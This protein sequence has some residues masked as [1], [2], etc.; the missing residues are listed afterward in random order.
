VTEQQRPDPNDPEKTER[1][2]PDK[3]ERVEPDKTERADSGKQ[4]DWSRWEGN[5]TERAARDAQR[6]AHEHAR[7]AERLAREA[8]RMGREHERM[9]RE[10]ERMAREK[11]REQERETR[12]QM[13]EQMRDARRAERDARRE[14][15]RGHRIEARAHGV[16]IDGLDIDGVGIGD[17]A[18][19][20]MKDF[21][22]DASGDSYS[23]TLTA[24]FTFE[25]MPR[26]RVRNISGETR[27]RV[28]EPGK[29]TV[30]AKK[31]VN[32]S[33]EDRAKRQ[34]QNLEIRMEKSGDELRIE[35]HLYEQERGWVDLFRGKRFRVDFEITVPQE[36][37]VD[38][39]TVS[40][41]LAV[42][43]VHGPL[44][45]QG[46]S[47]DITIEDVQGPLR[48][49]SVSGD[50]DCRRYVGHIEG[51]TVSGDVNF[52]VVRVR[53]LQL[54][55]VSGDIEIKGVLEAAR[56]HRIRTISGDIEL[57]LADPDLVVDFRTAS[58][59][60]E[61]DIPARVNRMSRKEYTVGLGEARGHVVAKTVSG[62]LTI[63]GTVIE[64]PGE[65]TTEEPSAARF[66]IGTGYEAEVD[67][68]S[69][70]EA[71]PAEPVVDPAARE[72]IRSVLERLA[73]GELGVDDAAAALDAK[74]KGA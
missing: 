73:K 32:A 58:G 53:S 27:V 64:V 62:D 9:G 12:E 39:Q 15:W 33:S 7:E 22:S 69:E 24:E 46:V 30:V 23:E 50:V 26:L 38:A 57:S 10:Q 36:C 44:E 52:D 74:R 47:G 31:H 18:K 14:E 11:V 56:E 55:T 1:V 3:T 35:P 13:R 19:G 68:E 70:V 67:A 59:D 2:E 42:S 45:I 8:E 6:A 72:A 60:L 40:G 63:R 48:L 49:K 20:F 25:R 51:N 5:N 43:G 21:V 71:Q 28:G 37:A 34:L 16:R 29:I 4:R 66:D 54:H 61:C 41:D 65:P 17:F